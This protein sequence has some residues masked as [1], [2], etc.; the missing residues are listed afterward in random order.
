MRFSVLLAVAIAGLAMTSSAQKV[1][2]PKGKP[3]Y[4]EEKETSRKGARVGK[5]TGAGRTSAASE[6][7][8]VEQS[9]SKVSGRRTDSSK[10]ARNNPALKAT[11]KDGNPAIRF[12]STGGSGKTGGKSGDA[13]KGRLRHKG[14]R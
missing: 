5:D 14:R 6:L 10:A 8:R 9:S 1:T 11:K 13:L 2:K 3:S 4:S 12:S 7:R